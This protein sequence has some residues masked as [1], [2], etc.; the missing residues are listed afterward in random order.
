MAFLEA[1]TAT[2]FILLVFG[3]RTQGNGQKVTT[4]EESKPAVIQ[5]ASDKTRRGPRLKSKE[6][7]NKRIVELVESKRKT[8][9]I[10]G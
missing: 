1:I 7:S 8:F 9:Q 3:F 5:V 4:S 6:V 2:V 10:S